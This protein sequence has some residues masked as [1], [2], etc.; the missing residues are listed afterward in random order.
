MLFG[1]ATRPMNHETLGHI[2]LAQAEGDGQLGLRKITRTALHH[3]RARFAAIIDADHRTDRVPVRF[4]P[5]Q[6]YAYAA[7]SG[8]LVI[9]V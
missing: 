5:Y 6:P 7:I 3:A 4:R 1:A 9:A 8:C 2:A